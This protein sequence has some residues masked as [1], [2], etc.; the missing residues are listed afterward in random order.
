[1]SRS[2]A[3]RTAEYL[4]C[5]TLRA[6]CGPRGRRIE[7]AAG[8]QRNGMADEP[9]AARSAAQRSGVERW[10]CVRRLR[11]GSS[12]GG[13]VMMACVVQWPLLQLSILL[14]SALRACVCAH[15]HVS[16]TWRCNGAH[17]DWRR[18]SL[19]CSGWSTAP[20]TTRVRDQW[21]ESLRQARER[22]W[23]VLASD[24]PSDGTVVLIVTRCEGT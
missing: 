8:A 7:P 24:E 20:P 19:W 12:S 15:V 21:S 14:W 10:Q 5:A 18:D 23:M 13:L 22:W 17:V 11:T 16:S 1:M 4:S 9:S 3:V 2:V 6:A